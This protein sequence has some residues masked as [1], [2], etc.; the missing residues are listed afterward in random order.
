[1]K[2]LLAIIA[3]VSIVACSKDEGGGGG[4]KPGKKLGVFHP[5]PY[6]DPV[7]GKHCNAPGGYCEDDKSCH[8]APEK[9]LAR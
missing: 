5:G 9:C 7:T 6:K 8:S 4:D 3:L 1:M 2:K